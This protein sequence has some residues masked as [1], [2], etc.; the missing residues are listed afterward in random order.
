MR[1]PPLARQASNPSTGDTG[2]PPVG[3]NLV[4][5]V[6]HEVSL[7]ITP[8]EARL[9][10]PDELVDGRVVGHLPQLLRLRCDVGP[11][12]VVPGGFFPGTV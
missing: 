11:P 7:A 9:R 5:A 8:E 3:G 6:P 4:V 10:M 12:H 2:A 1:P